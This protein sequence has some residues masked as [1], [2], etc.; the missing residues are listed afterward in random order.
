MDDC[1]I[2]KYENF[3]SSRW[4]TAAILEIVFGHNSAADCPISVK[5]CVKKQFFTEFRQRDIDTRVARS[6]EFSWCSLGFGERRVSCRLRY[7][8]NQITFRVQ[9]VD[10]QRLTIALKYTI[11]V[12]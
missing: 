3:Q 1:H 8:C 12:Y 7:T 4:R 5:S 11:S 9:S 2:T 10:V 6:T